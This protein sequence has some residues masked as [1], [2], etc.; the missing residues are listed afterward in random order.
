MNKHPLSQAI[1]RWAHE[2]HLPVYQVEGF[3]AIP[4][5][6]VEGRIERGMVRLV[7]LRWLEEQGLA[8]EEVRRTFAHYTNEGMS[9]PTS[10]SPWACA[11]RTAPSRPPTLP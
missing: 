4:G 7:N 2:R 6:G 3:T 5:A 8:D 9:E 10:A 1:A 11:A